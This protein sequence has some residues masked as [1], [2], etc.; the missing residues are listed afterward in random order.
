VPVPFGPLPPNANPLMRALAEEIRKRT[1]LRYAVWEYRPLPFAA[2]EGVGL[3]GA[4]HPF[5]V[6]RALT[7]L[8]AC[9]FMAEAEPLD[10]RQYGNGTRCFCPPEAVTS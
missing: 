1:G 4:T 9:G 8:V 3:A 7:R 6:S 10:T 2:S 5:Q